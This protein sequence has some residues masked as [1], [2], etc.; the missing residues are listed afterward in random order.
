MHHNLDFGNQHQQHKGVHGAFLFTVMLVLHVVCVRLSGF[1][2]HFSDLVRH[3]VLGDVVSVLSG[4]GSIATAVV[5]VKHY[6]LRNKLLSKE[7]KEK[8]G[9]TT[10][11][12]EEK[13]DNL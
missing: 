4:V 10:E 1:N 3:F 6:V 7:L 11:K 5:L 8:S 12:D 9:D 13:K 2:Y